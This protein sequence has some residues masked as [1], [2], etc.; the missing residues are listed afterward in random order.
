M[1]GFVQPNL[2]D[3]AHIVN[4]QTRNLVEAK[5]N[6]YLQTSE[7]PQIAVITVKRLNKLTPKYLN[8]SKKTVFI[9]VGEKDNKRNVQI[10]S[11]KDLH[12][13]FT[14][15]SRMNIIRTAG[16]ELRSK[17]N[18][19]FNSGLRFV[20]RACATKID[21]QYQYSLDKYDLTN[22]EQNKISHPHRVAL[23]IALALAVIVMGLIYVFRRVRNNTNDNNSSK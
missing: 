10:Y 19:K 15:E 11:S 4:K 6:R 20:F 3:G 21:Q 2:Q 14:A 22:A 17:S 12:S 16:D 18:A 1:T 13:A 9:V 7:Q 8:D 23:P 5:N